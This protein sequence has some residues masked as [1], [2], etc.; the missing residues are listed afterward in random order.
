MSYDLSA[1]DP[2]RGAFRLARELEASML[3]PLLALLLGF[4]SLIIAFLAA[5]IGEY[6]GALLVISTYFL[7]CGYVI[8]RKNPRPLW[9]EWL[10]L[11]A[12][13]APMLITLPVVARG[14]GPESVPPYALLLLAGWEAACAGIYLA[15]RRTT[16]PASRKATLIVLGLPVLVLSG[17]AFAA[18]QF[19]RLVTPLRI[20]SVP[21]AAGWVTKHPGGKLRSCTLASDAVIQRF[22]LPAGSRVDLLPSGQLSGFRL[23]REA[24]IGNARLPA[25]ATIGVRPDGQVGHVFLPYDMEIQGHLCLG[26]GHDWM[27]TFHPN[28]K[29]E[30]AWLAHEE[31]IQ[32][33]PCAK[34]SFWGELHGGAGVNFWPDGSLRHCRAAHRATIQGV[35]FGAGDQ[36]WLDAQGRVAAGNRP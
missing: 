12:L 15:S 10:S 6:S 21:C 23:G 14:E 19:G 29:L 22:E 5:E 26:R 28:G 31:V 18:Y 17:V 16:P 1:R 30:L 24:E 8:A 20:E 13:T 3:R 11:L 7:G 9:G 4:L 35:T 32:S 2:F 33:V 34:A 25:G 36:I 27:T